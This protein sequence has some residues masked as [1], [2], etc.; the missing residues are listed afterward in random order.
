MVFI[1]MSS[2]GLPGLNGFVGE[3]LVLMGMY[4]F[5]RPEVPG[6]LLSGLAAGGM[7]ARRLV[8]ADAAAARLLRRAEGA[9]TTK[10]TGRVAT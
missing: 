4:A 1:C 2:I 6:W 8:H 10:G 7:R 3:A 5:Q 9:G